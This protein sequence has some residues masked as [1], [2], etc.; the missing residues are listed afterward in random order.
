VS[1]AHVV[2]DGVARGRVPVQLRT[3][4]GSHVLRVEREGHEPLQMDVLLREGE[5][6]RV[7]AP[8]ERRS[9]VFGS[10]WLWTGIGV[11]VAAG[12]VTTVVLM[13]EREPRQGD[14]GPGRIS[15]PLPWP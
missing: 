2:L 11:L 7:D 6:R 14:I 3:R 15:A 1:G 13:G 4:P 10:W 5:H 8:L 12:A 9:S